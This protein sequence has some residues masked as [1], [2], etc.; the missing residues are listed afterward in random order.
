MKAV[1][2]QVTHSG[3]VVLQHDEVDIQVALSF[4]LHTTYSPLTVALLVYLVQVRR[5]VEV[6][7]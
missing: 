1:D 6:P 3:G 4:L 7:S 5:V 2:V